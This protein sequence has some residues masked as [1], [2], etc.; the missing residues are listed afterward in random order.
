MEKINLK[1]AG[2][3]YLAEAFLQLMFLMSIALATVSNVTRLIL[4]FKIAVSLILLLAI[5]VHSRIHNYSLNVFSVHRFSKNVLIFL[6]FICYLTVTIIYSHNQSYGFYKIIN[7][8]VSIL[9][10]IITAY[11]LAVTLDKKRELLFLYIISAFLILTVSYIITDYPFEQG[12]IYNFRPGRWS[13]VIYGRMAASAS[14]IIL[15]YVYKSNDKKLI[16]IYSFIA[17]IGIYGTYL[18]ALRSASLGLMFAWILF[19]IY[20][21]IDK[22]AVKN[23]NGSR[24]KQVTK[25]SLS[26]ILA[27]LFIVSIP[28]KDIVN[29]R[30]ESLTNVENLEFKNDAA[31]H[32]RLTSYELAVNMF[33]N[34]P[35]LGYGLGSFN[36]YDDLEWTKAIKYPHNLFLEIAAECGIIGLLLLFYLLFIL[37]KNLKNY[38]VLAVIFFL[39]ALFLSLFAKDVSTQPLLWIGFGFVRK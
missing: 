8:L 14:L 36:G 11:Y 9:P 24:I 15:F 19:I 22:D 4:I 32:S 20:A 37:F 2:L 3:K 28:H 23:I 26:F 25:I 38:S 29:L 31:I 7:F 6:L 35:L 30:F 17:A 12:T 34:K 13:H 39:F 27:A 10:L 5:I 16:L 33:I 1:D 18:S 21:F